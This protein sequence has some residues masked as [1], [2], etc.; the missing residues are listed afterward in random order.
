M[1]FVRKDLEQDETLLPQSSG[2]LVGAG[3]P[4]AAMPTEGPAPA[5]PHTGTGF[6]DLRQ[7][8]DA[9]TIQSK[10]LATKVGDTLRTEAQGIRDE[11]GKTKEGLSKTI[12][13]KNPIDANLIS[14]AKTTPTTVAGDASKLG[15]FQKLASG[16]Y[17]GPGGIEE[18]DPYFSFKGMVEGGQKKAG[19]VDTEP[20]R[21]ELLSGLG[22]PQRTRG[23]TLLD[24]YLISGSPENLDVVRGGAQDLSGTSVLLEDLGKSAADLI[25]GK[26]RQLDAARS[27]IDR[28]FLGEGGVVQG[29][30]GDL[31]SAYAKALADAQ[32]KLKEAYFPSAYEDELSAY[33]DWFNANQPAPTIPGIPGQRT[34]PQA[35]PAVPSI[36]GFDPGVDRYASADQYAREQ[37]LETLLGREF[38]VLPTGYA[39]RAGS[40]EQILRDLIAGAPALAP[41]PRPIVAPPLPGINPGSVQ[42]PPSG[43]SFPLGPIFR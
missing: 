1:A 34:G 28:E 6:V 19:L 10:D 14:E 33:T 13:E 16:T 3:T 38:D 8:L 18:Y 22:G 15:Q 5:G 21:F 43:T 36:P 24:Q 31:S 17:A 11:A 27:Q 20:G 32:A 4:G 7:Y 12:E 40:F 42:P 39:S 35:P 29:M 2:G 26:R 25:A 37:A 30:R 41:I 23:E 9:N